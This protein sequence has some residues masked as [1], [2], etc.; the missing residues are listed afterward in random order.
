MC[1]IAE[2][3]VAYQQVS[4]FKTQLYALITSG[5]A[6]LSEHIGDGLANVTSLHLGGNRGIA[7]Q[8]EALREAAAVSG[9]AAAL[10]LVLALPLEDD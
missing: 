1:V 2:Q 8:A 10:E 6:A 3:Y 7:A 9:R 5:V 4:R